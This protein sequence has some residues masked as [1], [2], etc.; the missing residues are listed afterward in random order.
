MLGI[1]PLGADGLPETPSKYLRG[2]KVTNGIEKAQAFKALKKKYGILIGLAQ[3]TGDEDEALAKAMPEFDL[4]LGGHSH[5][6]GAKSAM[7]NNVLIVRTESG[8]KDVGMVTLTVQGGTVVNRIYQKISLDS[9]KN[10]DPTIQAIVEKYNN[11]DEMD[12]AVGFAEAPVEGEHQLGSMMTD[13]VADRLKLDFAF[14]NI[15]GIRIS[16][17]PAGK[18]SLRDI[19]RLDPYGDMVIRYMM[20]PAEIR[21][22][23]CATFN[24]EKLLELEVSGMTYTAIADASGSCSNVEMLDRSGKPLDPEKDYS[25]GVNSYV[26]KLRLRSPRSR[27][28][29]IYDQQPGAY[30]L[31]G[32][33]EEGKL[34]RCESNRR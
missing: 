2:V 26:A 34:H 8:L 20:N 13:A 27:T 28:I 24:R 9:V 6:T 31:S 5:T 16:T 32:A 18:I 10:A 15:G 25:V 14:Q 29:D 3:L 30:R 19:Y 7:I 22:L 23:I 12:R 11:T 4:I 1:T 33:C 21:S 17:L